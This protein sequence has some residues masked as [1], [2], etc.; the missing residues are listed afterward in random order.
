MSTEQ[1]AAYFEEQLTPFLSLITNTSVRTAVEDLVELAKNR[2]EELA[3]ADPAT[4][5]PKPDEE[6]LN[7]IVI[8]I[9]LNHIENTAG[10]NAR[11]LVETLIT[12][13]QGLYE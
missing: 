5:I 6:E 11:S 7:N 2:E 1:N 10:T 9:D 12:Y 13:T 3:E 4:L 8:N